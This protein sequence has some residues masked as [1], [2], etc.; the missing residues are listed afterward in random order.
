MEVYQ[1]VAISGYSIL[2]GKPKAAEVMLVARRSPD[3]PTPQYLVRT[4]YWV[5]IK[6]DGV[7]LDRDCDSFRHALAVYDQQIQLAASLVR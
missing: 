1:C 2:I 6:D 7:P 3:S 5:G 4:T